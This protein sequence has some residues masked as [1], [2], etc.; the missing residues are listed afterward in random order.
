MV[1][2]PIALWT[3]SAFRD[4]VQAW[5]SA[6]LAPRGIRLTGDWEQS[7]VRVWSSAIRFETSEGR[8]WFKVSG[9]GTAYEAAL[10][11]VLS[12]LCPGLAPEVLAYDRARAWSLARDGGPM[13]RSIAAPDALW[14][15][16]ERLLPR[17]ANAQLALAEKRARLLATEIP[18]RGPAQLPV[19]LRRL[20]G[21]LAAR[22]I[23]DGGLSN[24][25]ARTLELLLPAYDDRCAELA[26]SGVPDSLQHDDLHSNNICWPGALDDLSSV[27]IVDWGDSSV[28]H[29]FGTMLATLNSI[30]F[31]AGLLH[32]DRGVI[33]DPRVLRVRDRLPRAVHRAGQPYGAAALARP[34]PEHRL[35]ESCAG[36]GASRAG[37]AGDHD[38]RR[39][40]DTR[41]A[42]GAPAAV[43]ARGSPRRSRTRS[44][45]LSNGS[46][47]GVGAAQIDKARACRL[48][49]IGASSYGASADLARFDLNEQVPNSVS[50][51]H[52]TGLPSRREQVIVRHR[53]GEAEHEYA[54]A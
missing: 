40:P 34:G 10:V 50:P 42:A 19:E 18:D 26:A 54:P 2:D 20:L 30:A 17:Y 32:D 16:W 44:V 14:C 1:L 29:P 5:V 49:T 41:L 3:S 38:R 8:V 46:H 45:S 22:P 33:E 21:E 9:S 28:G 6:Q 25:E 23:E 24:E 53:L 27:R 35:R 37:C 47:Q 51:G 39:V 43:D 13:L 15:Y 48:S 11:A 36:R 52:R 31:H 12:D 7:H 4:E